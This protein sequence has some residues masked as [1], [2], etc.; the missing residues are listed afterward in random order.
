MAGSAGATSARSWGLLPDPGGPRGYDSPVPSF[1]RTA[2]RSRKDRREE[3]LANL[4]DAVERLLA[5][6]R[7]Y[8]E[9]SV[10]RI[11]AAAGVSR[12]SFYRYVE[13][14]GE[15]LQWI[16]RAVDEQSS[17][18]G[19][20]FWRLP[21][22]ASRSD[23]SDALAGFVA[24]SWEH[25]LVRTAVVGAI[26]Y[27]AAIRTAH[28]AAVAA[29]IGVV[30]AH[31]VRGQREGWVRP[32]LDASDTAAWLVHMT[33]RGL[34]TYVGEASE[35]DLARVRDGLLEILWSILYA[36]WRSPDGGPLV[37]A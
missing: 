17:D 31:I 12:S 18:T 26:A 23:L 33:D 6:G 25:R 36:G 2:N 8:S 34:L 21:G 4:G 28:E 16:S 27:D 35:A 20:A 22:D 7:E 9:L 1:T 5:E 11:A 37:R 19:L 10:D 30:G 14:K 29:A 32:E 15:L 3:A 24:T 13:D